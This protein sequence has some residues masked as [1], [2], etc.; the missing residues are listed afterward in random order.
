MNEFERMF[1]VYQ[2]VIR[3]EIEKDGD[4]VGKLPKIQSLVL[5]LHGACK[6]RFST[7]YLKKSNEFEQSISQIEKANLANYANTKI[8]YWDILMK[9]FALMVEERY[10]LVSNLNRVDFGKG[11]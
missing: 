9:W 4:I 2:E 1:D 7:N 6:H 3:K 5:I 10:A 11:G 8:R